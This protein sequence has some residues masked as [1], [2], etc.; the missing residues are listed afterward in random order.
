MTFTST[1]KQTVKFSGALLVPTFTINIVCMF[2][3]CILIKKERKLHFEKKKT[4]F[5]VLLRSQPI[6][7]IVDCA[8]V[9]T[10]SSFYF[11]LSNKACYHGDVIFQLLKLRRI[12][13]YLTLVMLCKTCMSHTGSR[14]HLHRQHSSAEAETNCVAKSSGTCVGYLPLG[15]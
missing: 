13:I 8:H 4:T 6:H 2:C 3:Y 9:T 1:L 7:Q 11:N 10:R 5:V 14:H 15:G 12:E